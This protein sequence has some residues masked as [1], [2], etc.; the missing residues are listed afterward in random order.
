[1][2]RK[3]VF[4]G[5]RKGEVDLPERIVRLKAQYPVRLSTIPNNGSPFTNRSRFS[6]IRT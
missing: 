5:R 4:F 2:I 3:G 6:R 1:M